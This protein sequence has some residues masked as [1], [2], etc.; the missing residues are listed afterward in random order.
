MTIDRRIGVVMLIVVLSIGL[1]EVQAKVYSGQVGAFQIQKNAQVC[2]T[3][4]KTTKSDLSDHLRI[5]RQGPFYKVKVGKLE[6]PEKEIRIRT[7]SYFQNLIKGYC[8]IKMKGY[9]S[10]RPFGQTA[11]FKTKD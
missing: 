3:L 4:F 8:L 7:P 1:R 5:E 10:N 11:Y 9:Y 2:S 6:D